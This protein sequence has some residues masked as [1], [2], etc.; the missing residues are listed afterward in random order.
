MSYLIVPFIPCPPR[1]LDGGQRIPRQ[2]S[3]FLILGHSPVR[4][5]VKVPS[6]KFE[7]E[8]FI[9]SPPCTI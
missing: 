2:V 1:T 8:L 6:T 3:P 5:T 9:F 7:R 4:F